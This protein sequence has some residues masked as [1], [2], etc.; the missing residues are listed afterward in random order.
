MLE[1]YLE[2]L[3]QFLER[4]KKGSEILAD[5]AS[6]DG[7]DEDFF[8]NA[9]VACGLGVVLSKIQEDTGIG[10]VYGREEVHIRRTDSEAPSVEGAGVQDGEAALDEGAAQG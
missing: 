10:G 4:E 1:G 8:W 3:V 9:G 7:R 6:R 2:E 5:V